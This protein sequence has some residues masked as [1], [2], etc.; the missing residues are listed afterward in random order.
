MNLS[1]MEKLQ[2]LSLNNNS[3]EDEGALCLS[4]LF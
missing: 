4:M 3:I 2:H 1:K